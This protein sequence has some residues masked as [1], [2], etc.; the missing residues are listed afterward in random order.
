MFEIKVWTRL[1]SDGSLLSEH[2]HDHPSVNVCVLTSS[3]V[4]IPVTLDKGHY[5]TL[6]TF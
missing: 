2:S 6:T 1:V 4:R 5:F 3:F